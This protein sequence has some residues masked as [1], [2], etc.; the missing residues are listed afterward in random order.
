MWH[1]YK[2]R[3]CGKVVHHYSETDLQSILGCK[4][5]EN[6]A[7]VA[8]EVSAEAPKAKIADKDTEVSVTVSKKKSKMKVDKISTGGHPHLYQFLF[9]IVVYCSFKSKDLYCT[10]F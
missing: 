7:Q 2:R 10:D 5:D 9:V 6:G 3:E 8:I 1:R 4:S